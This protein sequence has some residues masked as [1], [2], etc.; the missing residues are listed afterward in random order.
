AT[1]NLSLSA[2]YFDIDYQGRI[3]PP[4]SSAE[5]F[6]AQEAYFASLITR[7]PTPAQID[8]VCTAK[9][10]DCSQPIAAIV[11][12][13]FRN[14]ASVRT[15]GVDFTLDY[16]IDGARSKWTFGVNGTYTFL[17]E[18]QITPAAPVLDLVNTVGNPLKLRMAAHLSWS[19]KGLTVL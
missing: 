1:P 10:G 6:F 18:Q 11:D 2:T 8:A 3:H 4:V 16:A 17:Q 14:L 5:V 9:I 15:R 7:N 19:M 12:Y 13:R